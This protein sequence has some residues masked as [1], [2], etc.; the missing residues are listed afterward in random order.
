MS[1]FSGVCKR[2]VGAPFAK[3]IRWCFYRQPSSKLR[4]NTYTRVP[5]SRILHNN[6]C[7]ISVCV[8]RAPLRCAL[9]VSHADG[10]RIEHIKPS[11]GA[12]RRF[13]EDDAFIIFMC[14]SRRAQLESLIPNRGESVQLRYAGGQL[15]V[16]EFKQEA[17]L[18]RCQ[19]SADTSQSD[20]V[21]GL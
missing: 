18:T 10:E 21:E 13:K 14:S 15:S 4:P 2:L 8:G 7:A 6:V 9:C 11:T 1:S 3:S 12:A 19:K 17:F 5:M 16:R 20:S